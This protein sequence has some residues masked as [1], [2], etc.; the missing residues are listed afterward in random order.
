ML[1]LL[2]CRL[3]LIIL[4]RIVILTFLLLFNNQEF[5]TTDNSHHG[6]SL[7]WFHTSFAV[8]RSHGELLPAASGRCV[9]RAPSW[10]GRRRRWWRRSSGCSSGSVQPSPLQG[11]SDAELTADGHKCTYNW[12]TE[13]VNEYLRPRCSQLLRISGWTSASSSPS[14]LPLA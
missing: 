5:S 8:T 1:I 11:R 7:P 12:K 14:E 6:F 4:S 13:H 3:S 10:P 2:Q 9:R